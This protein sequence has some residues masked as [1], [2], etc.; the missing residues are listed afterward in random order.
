MNVNGRHYRTVWL[1]GSTVFM[2]DQTLLPYEFQI[3]EAVTYKESCFAIKNM[4]TRGA[5]AIGATAG[6]AM[7]QAFMEARQ[8][9]DLH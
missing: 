2:I 4:I 6:F 1:E 7:V 5:G 3:F 9:K 8:E